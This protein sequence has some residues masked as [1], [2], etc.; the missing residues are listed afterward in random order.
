MKKIVTIACLLM[1]TQICFAEID[2]D[3]F[4]AFLDKQME[5]FQRG[6]KTMDVFVI[7]TSEIKDPPQIKHREAL[8]THMLLVDYAT[9]LQQTEML[10]HL[11]IL[12]HFI[13][14]QKV[15]EYESYL[16]NLINTTKEYAVNF[17]QSLENAL[18]IE[19]KQVS[20]EDTPQFLYILKAKTE[21]DNFV[22]EIAEFVQ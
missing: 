21:L 17:S 18:D 12:R 9:M 10:T 1:F 8:M 19:G 13:D 14:E 22:K 20:I 4:N 15:D 2:Y 6:L 16:Q 3:T 11:T 7:L 5:V